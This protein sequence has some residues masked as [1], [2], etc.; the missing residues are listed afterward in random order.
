MPQDNSITHTVTCPIGGCGKGLQQ[1]GAPG[2]VP[3][4]VAEAT[5]GDIS[6]SGDDR[7]APNK[8]L[9]PPAA[10]HEGSDRMPPAVRRRRQKSGACPPQYGLSGDRDFRHQITPA[11]SDNTNGDGEI[12]LIWQP[13]TRPIS[14]GQ[15]EAEVKGI[16]AGL[17]MLFLY[18]KSLCVPT[19]FKSARESIMTLF[20]PILKEPIT[21]SARGIP[22][23][24][25]FVQT[26]GILFSG[27]S[28]DQ[29]DSTM[30]EFV[31]R[32]DEHI[33]CEDNWTQNAVNTPNPDET[34]EM[35]LDTADASAE[36]KPNKLLAAAARL[37]QQ[38]Y[39]VVFRRIG[40]A[41]V[42]A[43]V[44][45]TL[46]F[47]FHLTSFPSAIALIGND[48][49]WEPLCELLNSLLQS[50]RK[51]DRIHG[52]EFPRQ[53]KEIAPRLLPEDFAMRG[54]PWVEKYFPKDWFSNDKLEE[55]EKYFE[56]KSMTEER[57]VRKVRIL[58][59][60]CRIAKRGGWLTYDGELHLFQVAAKNQGNDADM[61]NTLDLG[62]VDRG[63]STLGSGNTLVEKGNED[64]MHMD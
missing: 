40:D 9:K 58:W 3:S 56:K 62:R 11:E 35:V 31:S 46:V 39:M 37:A 13:Q 7:S 25:A 51:Y 48:F 57:K 17:V 49:P 22:I 20:I 59:L 43:F 47:V 18:T 23:N 19:P 34:T 29:F 61:M 14:V 50:Y 6:S 63:V 36:A 21:G 5:Q 24:V 30:E 16:Y 33:N 4:V 60:G 53:A 27:G 28:A 42:L 15:L 2:A 45:T 12:K 41:N 52:E 1:P 8:R 38:T 44:H 54:L 64:L 32:L 55:Q 10:Q 26:H